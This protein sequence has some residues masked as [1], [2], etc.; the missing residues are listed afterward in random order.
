M[1][2]HKVISDKQKAISIIKTYL[3]SLISYHFRVKRGFTLIEL[4]IVITIIAI[5][6]AAAT[7]SWQNA[8]IK[9]RDSKRKADLK[10][11]QQ[12]LE[13]YVQKNGKYPASNLGQ[14]QCNITGDTT[15]KAWGGT[16][17]CGSLTYL[18]QL[19]KD[20]AYQT[21]TGYYYESNSPNLTYTLS[22]LLE[23]TNDPDLTG[24]LCTPH[25]TAAGKYCVAN[26]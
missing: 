3:L 14:I 11:V 25:W 22:G 13:L 18:Q 7:T 23:N 15:I 21:T 19:P 2:F 8:Q 20:P 9:G 6:V 10:A 16:F 4:L 26:P 24:L 1:P 17:I 12:S 5:L